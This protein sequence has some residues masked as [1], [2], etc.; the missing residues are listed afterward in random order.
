MIVYRAA[1]AFMN[2]TEAHLCMLHGRPCP[3]AITIWK[4]VWYRF[5]SGP[6]EKGEQSMMHDMQDLSAPGLLRLICDHTVLIS[7]YVC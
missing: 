2:R 6:I 3:R 5:M 1:N 7:V 4:Q